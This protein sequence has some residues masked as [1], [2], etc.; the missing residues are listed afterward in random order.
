MKPIVTLCYSNPQTNLTCTIHIA[1]NSES[2]TKALQS[3]EKL[4][5]YLA[6]VIPIEKDEE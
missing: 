1:P 5:G 6:V 4:N 2:I 3:F